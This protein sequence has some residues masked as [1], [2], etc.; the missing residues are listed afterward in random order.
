MA[1]TYQAAI[2]DTA[3]GVTSRWRILWPPTGSGKTLGAKVY[4]VLQAEQNAAT[5]DVR[6]PVGILIVTRLIA[7]ADEMVNAINTLAGRKVAVADH[8]ADRATHEQLHESDV[9]VVTHQAY[10]NAT[11]T[12]SNAGDSK[13]SLLTNWRGG[14]RL[15]TIIDE[16]LCN[17]I[18]ESQVDG[19]HLNRVIGFIPDELRAAYPREV[20]ALDKLDWALGHHAG[21]SEVFFDG[22]ACMAWDQG[23]TPVD[24]SVLRAEMLKLPYDSYVGSADENERKR[25]ASLIDKTLAAVEAVLDQY[26]YFALKG[27]KATLNSSKLAVPLDAPGPVVLDAT[28]REDFIYK[29]MEDHADI[30]PTTLG[31][32]GWQ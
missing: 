27:T 20:E 3:A 30:V 6:K 17:I 2:I 24:L 32:R 21:V 15:L 22:G 19:D 26:A 25:I 4:A 14:R 8:S 16:A 1:K 18:E 11:Q 9:L 10:V 29:L 31:R 5:E 28:A 13:W 7:Q 23:Q 12:F